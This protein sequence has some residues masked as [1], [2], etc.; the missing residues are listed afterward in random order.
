MQVA[1]E[2]AKITLSLAI[3]FYASWR[4]Y[5]TREV[6]NRAWI[7]YAPPALSLSLAEL[8]LYEPA[9]LPMFGLSIGVTIAIAFVLFYSGG[10]GGADSKALMCIAMALPF[11]PSTLFSPVISA[12]LS[13]LAQTIFP[14][15]VLSN[16]VLIAAFSGIVLI[17]YNMLWRL[18]TRQKLFEGTLAS[19]KAWKKL[20]VLITGYRVNVAKLRAKWHIYPLEDLEENSDGESVSRRLVVVPKDEG[21]DD[22]VTRLSKAAEAGK[23]G[24]NVWATPGLPMLIFVTVGLIVALLLGDV[25]WLLVRLAFE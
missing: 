18:R 25:V 15:T 5:K 21:R 24:S 13:P 20:L 8:L 14:L 23:I 9:K 10:F 1:L 11:A 7:I 22:V 2:A 12:A 6:T 19:E 16:S 17:L 4:D 3:L